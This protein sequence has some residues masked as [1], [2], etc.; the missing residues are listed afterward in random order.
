MK[1]LRCFLS[2]LLMLSLVSCNQT[3]LSIYVTAYPLEY[4]AQRLAG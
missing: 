4:V 2:C 3:Q 1:M